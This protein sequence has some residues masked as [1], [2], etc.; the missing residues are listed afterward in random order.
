MLPKNRPPNHPGEIL[1]EEF[2]KPL[3]MSQRALALKLSVEPP[4]VS[5]IVHGKRGL[6]AEMAIKL[7]H[8]FD[9]TPEVWMNLQ[10][11]WDLWHA[12]RKLEKRA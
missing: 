12:A 4:V 7:A 3:H 5:E 10:S 9:T 2:L 8:V 11:G 1:L 6:S